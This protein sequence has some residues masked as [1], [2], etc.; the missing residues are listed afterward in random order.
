[1]RS[2]TIFLGFLIF[3]TPA[4]AMDPQE[5]NLEMQRMQIEQARIQANGMAMMGMGAALQNGINQ[6]FHDMQRTVPAM[7]YMQPMQPIAPPPQPL[8]C[9]QQTYGATMPAVT[10]Y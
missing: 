7:P 9:I 4:F 8:R 1:M 3:A 2:C 10:C 5:Y 6:G